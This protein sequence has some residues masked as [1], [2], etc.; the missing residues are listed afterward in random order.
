MYIRPC[1]VVLWSRKPRHG[2]ADMYNSKAM[3]CLTAG[4]GRRYLRT[5]LKTCKHAHV[6]SSPGLRSQEPEDELMKMVVPE[7]RVATKNCDAEM[8]E[9]SSQQSPTALCN[10][11]D[12]IGCEPLLIDSI[13]SR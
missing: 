1:Y 9:T 11:G 12:S 8:A 6:Y 7:G 4:D 5:A 3:S 2:S 10:A 13:P